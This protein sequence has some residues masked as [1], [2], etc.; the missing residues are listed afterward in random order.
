M[1]RCQ[2]P[3]KIEKPFKCLLTFSYRVAERIIIQT[4]LFV[5]FF[6]VFNFLNALQSDNNYHKVYVLRHKYI[7][8]PSQ[9][10]LTHIFIPVKLNCIA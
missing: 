6:A 7:L 10:C 8:G 9:S 2:Q 4:V 5:C 3:I 1:V